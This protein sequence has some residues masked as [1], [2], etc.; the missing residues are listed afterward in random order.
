MPTNTAPGAFPSNELPTA[1]AAGLADESRLIRLE[2][3]EV[4]SGGIRV[5][6]D[7]Y[8]FCPD[9]AYSNESSMPMARIPTTILRLA[10]HNRRKRVIRILRASPISSAL[11]DS[12]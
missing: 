10:Q 5:V 4:L 7:V 9:K 2:L 12:M 11:V 1:A 8:I 6:V 3:E